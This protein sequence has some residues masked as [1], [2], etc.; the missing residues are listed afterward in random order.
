MICAAAALAY[1]EMATMIPASGSAYTYTYVVLGELLDSIGRTA[2]QIT[3]RELPGAG[4][5]QQP[6][7]GLPTGG[8]PDAGQ[9][10]TSY[11]DLAGGSDGERDGRGGSGRA[12][13]NAPR[14]QR[15]EPNAPR[16]NNTSGTPGSGALD[17]RI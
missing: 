14:E 3:F 17:V 11:G 2:G 5:L 4:Q 9:A 7:M 8:Q 15:A 10:G 12:R 16:G 6:P 1:A 13:A